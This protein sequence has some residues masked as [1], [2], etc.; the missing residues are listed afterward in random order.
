MQ[1]ET[2]INE[3]NLNHLTS[4]YEEAAIQVDKLQE[5]MTGYKENIFEIE[6]AMMEKQQQMKIIIQL[7]IS[8]F[9]KTELIP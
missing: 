7:I 3:M 8:K 9:P 5:R 1:E 2:N 6:L 4:K